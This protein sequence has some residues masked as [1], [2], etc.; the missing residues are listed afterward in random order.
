MKRKFSAPVAAFL[1]EMLGPY[2]RDRL[3]AVAAIHGEVRVILGCEVADRSRVYPWHG[4]YDAVGWRRLTLFPD[5]YAEDLSLLPR[6]LRLHAGLL[7]P[8]HLF[9]AGYERPELFLLALLRRLSGR[10]TVLM[11]DSKFDDKPRRLSLEILKAFLCWPYAAAL[12]AGPRQTDYVRFLGFRRRPVAMGYDVVSCERVQVAARRAGALDRA[13]ADR[14]FVVVARFAPKK[15]LGVVL[16]A[17][18]IYLQIFPQ[19]ARRLQLVG[20]GDLEAELRRQVAELGLDGR[21]E[22]HGFV[23]D[24]EVARL[25]AEALALILV[26]VE[27]QWGLVVNEALALQVPV[28]VSTQVGARDSLVRSHVNGFIVESDNPEGL[29]AFMGQL[30]D[31]SLWER[32]RAGTQRFAPAADVGAFTQGVGAILLALDSSQPQPLSARVG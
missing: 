21:V 22:L 29:A 14:P 12:V 20:G 23:Q 7:S 4:S 11:L 10:R 1:W 30:E 31:Q 24:H 18:K 8:S 2:H 13:H 5:R 28:L 32:L 17:F 3:V 15:N 9:L 6:F 27:E 25:L 16:Q 26:S 19:S